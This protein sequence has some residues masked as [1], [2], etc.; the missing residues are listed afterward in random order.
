MYGH[1]LCMEDNRWPKPGFLNGF[2]DMSL[3]VPREIVILKKTS[4]FDLYLGILG[5][6]KTQ[7]ILPSPNQ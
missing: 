7:I 6:Y 5:W 4:F 3:G 1:A 2:R